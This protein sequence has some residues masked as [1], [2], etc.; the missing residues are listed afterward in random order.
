MTNTKYELTDETHPD[1]PWLRR[2]RAEA[3]AEGCAA[4]EQ[5]YKRTVI[6][7]PGLKPIAAPM[8]PHLNG[9]E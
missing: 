7:V 6:G 3:W 8:N 2:I 4:A 9:G 5:Y 1:A